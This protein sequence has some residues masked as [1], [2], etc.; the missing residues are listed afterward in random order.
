MRL[1]VPGF[2]LLIAA[3]TSAGSDRSSA[4]GQTPHQ[5]CGTGANVA[6]VHVTPDSVGPITRH[7]TR[8]ELSR[9]CP[10]ALRDTSWLGAEAIPV[11]VTLVQLGSRIVAV[12]WDATDS[13]LSRAFIAD[14]MLRTAAG[15]GVGSPVSELRRVYGTLSAGYDDEGVHVWPASGSEGVSFLVGFQ[16]S[17]V[18]R[19]PDD[20]RQQ[21][22]LVPDTARV[23]R[24]TLVGAR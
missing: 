6:T 22:E 9:R 7:L 10:G 24:I 1:L 4:R 8:A 20:V 14:S 16:A 3:C 18:L 21:P 19:A 12:E 5:S 11:R 2:G 23:R 15:I 13:V 17:S